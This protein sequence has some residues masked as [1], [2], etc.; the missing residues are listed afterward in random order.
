M[1]DQKVF[2]SLTLSDTDPDRKQFQKV[3]LTS[4]FLFKTVEDTL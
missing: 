1:R 3:Q 2:V 4:N